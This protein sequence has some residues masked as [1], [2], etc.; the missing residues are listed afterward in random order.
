[1]LHRLCPVLMVLLGLFVM[2]V[3]QAR[4]AL[5]APHV[6]PHS[7]STTTQADCPD[8][9][10][11]SPQ[12]SDSTC[13]LHTGSNA[14][15]HTHSLP[16]CTV[17]HGLALARPAITPPH[18]LLASTLTQPPQA[19]AIRPGQRLTPLLPPPRLHQA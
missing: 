11:A 6:M 19:R 18:P 2:A 3:P 10:P 1:M 17:Q 9:P 8:M 7:H 14:T 5:A 13:C 16:C 4:M 15:H 12:A